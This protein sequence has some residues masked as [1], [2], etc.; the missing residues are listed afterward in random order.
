[1]ATLTKEVQSEFDKAWR[2]PGF[3]LERSSPKEMLSELNRLLE[4]TNKRP[5][6]FRR[7]SQR[8]RPHEIPEEM[9]RVI[10]EI[11]NAIGI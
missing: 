10:H 7:L 8:M 3:R 5:V 9:A 2:D 11:E 6:S 4:R 1:L